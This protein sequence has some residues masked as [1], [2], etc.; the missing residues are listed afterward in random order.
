[1][2]ANATQTR[3]RLLDEHEVAAMLALSVRTL[4]AWR[5]KGEGPRFVRLG[6]AIRYRYSD[7][8]VWLDANTLTKTGVTSR[9]CS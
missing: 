5:V 4:Q 8:V 9:P 3:D 2:L 6:R 7:V 1:M